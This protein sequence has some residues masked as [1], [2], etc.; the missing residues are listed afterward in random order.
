ME[1]S[2]KFQTPVIL[3]TTTRVSH[4]R[5]IVN[6]SE[7]LTLAKPA[8]FVKNPPRYVPIPIWG[9]VMRRNVEERTAKLK[10]AAAQSPANR[11]EMRDT[12]LG[13]IT[14]SIAYEYVRE[15]W[16]E[17]SVLKLGWAYPFPDELILKFA[18]Q[19]KKL[20]VVEE[21]DDFLEEHIKALGIACDGSNVIPHVGELSPTVLRSARSKYEGRTLPALKPRANVT[22]LPS[23]PPVLCPSCP[24]RG[25][26]YALSQFDVVVTATLAVTAWAYFRRSTGWIRYCAWARRLDDA[27]I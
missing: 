2:E 10:A 17:A 1:L 14:S 5:S 18:G 20:L 8:G 25:I 11:I 13:I 15:I 22:D 23:R 27:G 6:L 19:V 7:R 12:Q 4:S 24:H 21:L 16:P 26:F 9:R 3:R